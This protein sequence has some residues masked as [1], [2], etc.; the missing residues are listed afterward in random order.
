M[1]RPWIKLYTEM[2][3]DPKVGQLSDSAYR[4]FVELMLKAGQVDE[5]GATDTVEALA[6]E[7]RRQSDDLLNLIW[8]LEEGGRLVFLDP[9]TQVVYITS[10]A[11][12]QPPTTS[13]ERVKRHRAKVAAQTERDSSEHV[14]LHQRYGNVL[15]KEIDI[16]K[17]GEG[18]TRAHAKNGASAAPSASPPVPES[19]TNHA[20][21]FKAITGYWVGTN[22]QDFLQQ[23]LGERPDW[24]VV[25]WAYEQWV[26]RGYNP[27]NLRGVLEWYDKR[28]ADPSWVPDGA[29]Q[30]ATAGPDFGQLFEDYFSTIAN[31]RRRMDG[32]IPQYVIDAVNEMGRS[33]FQQCTDKERPFL[34]R[35]F[36]AAA[37]KYYK[38][39]A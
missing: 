5:D 18:E 25:G 38:V 12:R 2:L 36:E 21:T 39:P 32:E 35:D 9:E 3:H 17:E 19:S 7:L 22:M 20:K 10:W 27:R 1:A 31:R 11:K 34:K 26:T 8:E 14:T 15:D 28:L 30:P 23:R 29:G 6:W 37:R 4:L 33:R 16:D 24:D 13:A